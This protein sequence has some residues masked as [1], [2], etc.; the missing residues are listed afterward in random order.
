MSETPEP[1]SEALAVPRRPWGVTVATLLLLVAAA[2]SMVSAV[3]T[4]VVFIPAIQSWQRSLEANGFAGAPPHWTVVAAALTAV[5][6]VAAAVFTVAAWLGR[7][8]AYPLLLGAT[9]M[10]L[11]CAWY[12][13]TGG[14]VGQTCA[15]VEWSSDVCGIYPP[16]HWYFDRWMPA[17]A[18]TE[19]VAW[20]GGLL[21]LVLAVPDRF[22]SRAAWRLERAD[23]DDPGA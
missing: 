18:T 7:S 9:V 3:L 1:E 5:V 16:L 11:P 17:L 21:L 2:A 19:A 6:A 8:A 13:G 22:W 10:L 23:T 14:D 20:L 4:L 12:W 15:L